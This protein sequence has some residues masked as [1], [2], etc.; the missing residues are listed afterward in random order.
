M[1]EI[2][3]KIKEIIITKSEVNM[4]PDDIGDTDYLLFG[5]LNLDSITIIE[6]L[7]ALEGEFGITFEDYELT[8]ESMTSVNVI[9]ELIKNKLEIDA[10]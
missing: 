5:G 2:K 1:K 3:D 6:I 4:M 8:E 10:I 9:A 7:V